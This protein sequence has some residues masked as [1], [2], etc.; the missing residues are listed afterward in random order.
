MADHR[1]IER[2]FVVDLVPDGLGVHPRKWMRQGYLVI[3]DERKLT[4]R[5]RQEGE[6]FH[7]AIKHGKG[8]VRTEV[9]LP[10]DQGQF[11]A[12]WSEA[13]RYSLTKTRYYVDYNDVRVEVDLYEGRL[14]GLMTAEVEFESEEAATA[15]RPPPWLGREVTGDGRYLNQNL[16][17]YGRPD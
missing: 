15:F 8:I 1:E 14:Q 6:A 11:E 5:L 16:A 3:D 2:K 13:L 4:V 17:R 10:L 9:D 12:L 7:L